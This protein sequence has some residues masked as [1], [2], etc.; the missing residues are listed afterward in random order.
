MKE[1]SLI[2]RLQEFRG[3][4]GETEVV[5]FK[6]AKSG[7]DFTKLGR[8]FSALSNEANLAGKPDAWLVFG[9]KNNPHDIVGTQFRLQRT[10]LDHLKG[11]IA[12]KTTN[13]ISFIEIHELSL[14]EGRVLMFQIPAAPKGIPIAFDGHY[15]ARDG[16]E[17]SPLNL[18][19]I[20][21]IRSGLLATDWSAGI[22]PHATLNDLDPAAISMARKKYKELFPKKAVDVDSWDDA[23]FLDKTK[24]TIKK[25][26]TRTAILLLGKEESEHFLSP[27]EAKIRYLLKDAQGN[28]RDHYIIGCP[29][30]LAI[31]QVYDK[32]RNPGYMYMNNQESLFP[33]TTQT[34][35]P[36]VIREALNNCIAHQD[37]TISGRVN[38]V[39][40]DDQLIFSNKG[41][42][43]P[44]SVERVV[45]EDTP[46]EQYRNPFLAAAMVNV[47]LIET[48]GGGIRKM[49]N[50][51][52][53]RFF[54]MPEYDFADGSVKVTI[55]G[56]VLDLS[57]AE[58][59]ARNKDLSLEE[60]IML[61]KL[62]KKKILSIHEEK[63]L[64][65]RGLIEGKRPNYFISLKLAQKT[66]QKAAYTKN[67]AMEKQYYVDLI[68]K[69]LDQH[70]KMT[71]KE[72]DELLW[73][74]LPDWMN[75]QQ[76]KKKISNL[77]SE[78]RRKKKIVDRG[79]PGRPIWFPE[80]PP[81]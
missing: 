61:D 8:Y 53:A 79:I 54:P 10:D 45:M 13:R 41:T 4:P 33:E 32:I 71:R 38:V 68:S 26:I 43:I 31:D 16:E 1:A 20:E 14:P 22:L 64:K 18:E 36:F 50:Y 57:Y 62:Q 58:V 48:A 2:T 23:H 59:L 47:K 69:A 25:Q 7:Y 37:Y 27:A 55:T 6:E 15:Y 17:L 63:H 40:M 5:E 73:L 39:E 3:L 70:D 19:K 74:K 49:H 65:Q 28:N 72:I 66:D 60:I 52:R 9:V 67:R 81:I 56:K 46:E 35:E 34:Y 44:V 24:F 30:L 12:N 80:D 29:L 11:E 21:R 78:M 42:F 77:L 51:Q 76:K 75:D